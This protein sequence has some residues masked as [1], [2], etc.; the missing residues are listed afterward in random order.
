[1]KYC[2]KCGN[3]LPSEESKFCTKCGASLS[4]AAPAATAPATQ[5]AGQRKTVV[6]ARAFLAIVLAAIVTLLIMVNQGALDLR[7]LGLNNL[8]LDNFGLNNFSLD[9]LGLNITI[10]TPAPPVIRPVGITNADGIVY[11]DVLG[12]KT[13]FKFTGKS[14][15]PLAGLSVAFAMDNATNQSVLLI[16]DPSDK[17]PPKIVILRRNP[18]ATGNSSMAPAGKEIF[19]ANPD[20]ETVGIVLDGSRNYVVPYRYLSWLPDAVL[21]QTGLKDA[22]VLAAKMADQVYGLPLGKYAEK[23]GIAETVDQTRDEALD[24]WKNDLKDNAKKNFLFFVDPK[25]LLTGEFE[26]PTPKSVFIDAA[27]LV[28]DRTTIS[29][30]GLPGQR[31]TMTTIGGSIQIR[32]CRNLEI[33]DLTAGMLRAATGIDQYGQKLTSGSLDLIS[34]GNIGLAFSIPLDENGNAQAKV[35]KG[36]YWTTISADGFETQTGDLQVGDNG[37]DISVNLQPAQPIPTL[38]SVI[39]PAGNLEG[40]WSG[41]AAFTEKLNA[42]IGGAA[43]CMTTCA[44]TGTVTLN[45]RQQGNGLQGDFAFKIADIKSTTTYARGPSED[46]FDIQLAEPCAIYEGYKENA[47][48]WT[49]S[50]TVS[51]SSIKLNI[52]SNPTFSGSFT[53]G[54]MSLAIANC[55]VQEPRPSCTITDGAKWKIMLTRK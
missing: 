30:C 45:L 17:L 11:L 31:N 32:G 29:S 46:S 55:F 21:D 26:V 37:V 33:G 18:P 13:A 28:I 44:Y 25:A 54:Q 41:S 42:C 22:T 36:E 16:I 3:K 38:D 7:D 6:L 48:T 19:F 23:L 5:P 14:R 15:E 9:N 27:T 34:K 4:K 53:S 2:T 49:V 43:G 47:L 51:S 35:P 39:T 1:M 52:G 12:R 10:P 24:S 40:T 8:G 20:M 50:G